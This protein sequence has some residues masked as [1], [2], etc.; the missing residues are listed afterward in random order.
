MNKNLE[1]TTRIGDTGEFIK[2]NLDKCIGCGRCVII[3]PMN[4][5]K[6]VN[7]KASIDDNYK[8][9]C[10]ECAHCYSICENDAIDFSYPAGGTGI[11]FKRG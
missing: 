4:L 7:R 11:I 10:L 5:W 1:L 9:Q 8:E 6:I 3:C 2:I